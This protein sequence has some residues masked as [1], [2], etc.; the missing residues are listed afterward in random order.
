ML[1]ALSNGSSGARD[2]ICQVMSSLKRFSPEMQ[3]V[4]GAFSLLISCAQQGRE[5]YNSIP[6]VSEDLL[7][8]RGTSIPLRTPA[9]A[10]VRWKAIPDQI[11]TSAHRLDALD[12]LSRVVYWLFGHQLGLVDRMPMSHDEA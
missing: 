11:S 7:R 9:A 12:S 3:L 1:C 4:A 5:I 10:T 8:K 6:S 2:A